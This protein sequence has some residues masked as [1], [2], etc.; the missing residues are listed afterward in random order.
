[1]SLNMVDA[2]LDILSRPFDSLRS[3]ELSLHPGHGR[4][5]AILRQAST[6]L[7]RISLP[8]MTVGSIKREYTIVFHSILIPDEVTIEAC[9]NH[10]ESLLRCSPH[11][12]SFIY[13]DLPMRWLFWDHTMS[14]L[15]PT[16]YI[17]KMLNLESC[18]GEERSSIH[19]TLIYTTP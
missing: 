18:K 11:H 19:G 15:F 4:A 7:D 10:E 8:P 17:K 1:M 2:T 5:H 6:I 9:R 13:P 16:L 14:T 12:I 3:L